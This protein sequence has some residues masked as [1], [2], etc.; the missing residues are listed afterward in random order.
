M[1]QENP[2]K[3][4]KAPRKVT[5]PITLDKLDWGTEETLEAEYRKT[6]KERKV[7]PDTITSRELYRDITR[8]PGPLS[9]SC[10]SPVW[11][12]WWIP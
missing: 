5:K 7:L 4:K 3:Q 9:A 1:E 12:P 2:T 11:Y 6:R 10:S 8:L